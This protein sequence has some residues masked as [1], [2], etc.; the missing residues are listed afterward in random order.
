MARFTRTNTPLFEPVVALLLGILAGSLPDRPGDFR[1]AAGLFTA[2]LA[3]VILLKFIGFPRIG[4]WR[5]IG[6]WI[7]FY[8]LGIV[9]IL[10]HRPD[11]TAVE[12]LHG[13]RGEWM[14][15]V[16]SLPELRGKWHRAEATL[17]C[18]RENPTASWTP[19]GFPRIRLYASRSDT[20]GPQLRTGD[21]LRFRGRL[22]ATSDTVAYDRYMLRTRSLVGR[23][24]AYRVTL[25]ERDPTWQ[26]RIELFRRELGERLRRGST[27]STGS[28]TA[29][30]QALTL[31]QTSGLDPD[32]RTRYARTGLAHL[33]A[34]SGLHVGIIFV[35]LNLLFGWIRL[36]RNGCVLSGALVIAALCGYALLTGLSP[37]VVRAVVMFSLLQIGLM[38]SR[39]T[40]SLNTLC[41]AALL[42][43]LWNPYLLYHI[44]FQLSFAATASI[45]TLY[46]PLARRWMPRRLIPRWLWSLTLVSLTAQLGVFPL[47]LYHFG[48]IQP[49]GLL[50]NPVVWFTV[51]TLI[52][53]SVVYLASGWSWLAA[54]IHAVAGWQNRLVER[55]ASAP[56]IAWDGIEISVWSCIALY[57]PVW[58]LMWWL[59]RSDGSRPL[60]YSSDFATA[61]RDA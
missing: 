44:G 56:W 41:A 2:L 29:L 9:L 5:R 59:N 14:A 21:L 4:S 34:V 60:P 31:G 26:T 43:L 55:C 3:A 40:N 13:S 11:P 23:C 54:A 8:S 58:A 30:L 27:D 19:L 33:L 39:S 16:E 17:L 48:Q 37:S 51:P 52:V 42:L 47:I 15:R 20:T 32:L 61:R 53:G 45:I 38:L 35:L 6:M 24:F 12:T 49:G 22:Y 18:Y 57:L 10:L 46:P 36:F 28:T 50:L 25:L 7:G 1:L